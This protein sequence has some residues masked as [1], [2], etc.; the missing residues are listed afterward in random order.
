MQGSVATNEGAELEVAAA[1][2]V[3]VTA[4]LRGLVGLITT[5]CFNACKTPSGATQRRVKSA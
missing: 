2:D 3:A 4:V 1:M 5:W